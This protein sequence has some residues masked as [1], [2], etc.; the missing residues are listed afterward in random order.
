MLLL[1]TVEFDT[2]NPL[3]TKNEILKNNIKYKRKHFMQNVKF[4]SYTCL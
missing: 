3:W 4:E 2:F 1:S